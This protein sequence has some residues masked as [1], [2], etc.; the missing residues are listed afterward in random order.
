MFPIFTKGR[1]P[2]HHGLRHQRPR[3]QGLAQVRAGGPDRIP[4]RGDKVALQSS[5]QWMTERLGFPFSEKSNR[6]ANHLRRIVRVP[7]VRALK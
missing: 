3:Q 5:A 2:Q 7:L 4:H 1:R 6:S